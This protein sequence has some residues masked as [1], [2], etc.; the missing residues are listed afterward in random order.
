MGDL[1]SVL[2]RPSPVWNLLETCTDPA[3]GPKKL[4]G[5]AYNERRMLDTGT[6]AAWQRV[7]ERH[8]PTEQNGRGNLGSDARHLVNGTILTLSAPYRGTVE[9]SRSLIL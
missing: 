5:R 3:L 1:D 2:G 7:R 8:T 6:E 9:T 4:F